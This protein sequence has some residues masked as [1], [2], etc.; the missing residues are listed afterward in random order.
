MRILGYEEMMA[1][2][3]AVRILYKLKLIG[4]LEYRTLLAEID[5]N[6]GK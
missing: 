1:A 3:D 6:T 5:R 4:M 2:K